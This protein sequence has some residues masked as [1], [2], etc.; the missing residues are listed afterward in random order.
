MSL[1]A[2][3]T[4]AADR[5][6]P[7]ARPSVARLV[8][9]RDLSVIAGGNLMARRWAPQ[10]RTLGNQSKKLFT[11]TTTD[12]DGVAI[13]GVTVEAWRVSPQTLAGRVVSDAL[14]YYLLP[15]TA[16]DS[17]FLAAF[18]SGTPDLVGKTGALTPT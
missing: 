8:R 7:L 3:G 4:L 18:K 2:G 6:H 14:G 1:I 17:Q 13:G 10:Q 12:A 11:G 15:T 16:T 5:R 9:F